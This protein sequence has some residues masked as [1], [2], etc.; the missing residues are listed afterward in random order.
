MFF[1]FVSVDK[2]LADAFVFGFGV[3]YSFVPPE[4]LLVSLQRFF[5]SV[6]ES[7]ETSSPKH[8]CDKSTTLRLIVDRSGMHSNFA[9]P[10]LAT[11][12]SCH[13][14]DPERLFDKNRT[15]AI[16]LSRQTR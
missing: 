12:R 4:E 5:C 15:C 11:S 7:N 6:D 1:S 13:D 16:T 3:G 8:C 14:N 9:L 10:S 2:I